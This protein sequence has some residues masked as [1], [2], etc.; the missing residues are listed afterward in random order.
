MLPSSAEA[1]GIARAADPGP[2]PVRQVTLE[3]RTSRLDFACGA[4][5][6]LLQA[7]LR[8]GVALPYECAT[9]TC[10]SCRARVMDGEVE[11]AWEDAPGA[12]RLRRER[13]DILLC[14]ARARSDLRLRVPAAVGA[15]PSR[16]RLPQHRTGVIGERRLLTHDVMH[17]ELVLSA[18]MSFEAGQFAVI[19]VP[20]LEGGRAYS[21]VNY[22]EE[23]RRL[24]FVV[25][26]KPGGGFCDW[27]FGPGCGQQTLEVFGPLGSATFHPGERRNLLMVAGGSGI[28]GMMSILARASDGNHF[29]DHK[30]RLFFGVRRLA[31][32]FYLD[33]LEDC[34]ARAGG[35]LEVTLA[36]SDETPAAATHPAHPR[37]RLA[38]GLVHDAMAE[39]MQGRYDNPLAYV[40]GPPQMVDGAL[41]VMI[42]QGQITAKDI[43]HDKFS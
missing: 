31:D 4:G 1:P 43:R 26:R 2:E 17:F 22:R 11:V 10:G 37:I 6:T 24:E 7:G 20:G 30:A 29:R 14:Q 33:R 34:V 38:A 32:G 3:S 25:K 18:P 23:A 40:A 19:R 42:T 13:G 9:G 35:N 39:A 5:E 27:L 28:A 8:Q 16:C 36:L 41:R 12:A 15:G 21:M